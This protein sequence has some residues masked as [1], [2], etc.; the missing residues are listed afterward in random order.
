MGRRQGVL[1]VVDLPGHKIADEIYGRGA[2]FFALL[3][4]NNDGMWVAQG[5]KLY[6]LAYGQNG[7]EKR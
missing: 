5:H 2:A 3:A 1:A 7:F 6:H 4:D